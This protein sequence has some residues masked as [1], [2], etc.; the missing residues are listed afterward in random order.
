VNASYI[1]VDTIIY[2]LPAN[3]KVETLPAN[4]E[5]NSIFG[6]YSAFITLKENTLMYIRKVEVH[7]GHYPAEKYQEL[8]EFF[9][10][11][12]KADKCKAIFNKS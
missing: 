12:S 3:V 1:D 9:D 6:Q 11:V 4:A 7:R 10:K 8:V 5:I 2:K